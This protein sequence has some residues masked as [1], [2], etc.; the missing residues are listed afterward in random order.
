MDPL[1]KRKV[2]RHFTYGMHIIL[3]KDG[4]ELNG[5]TANFLTQV[6]FDPPL[7]ALSV[8][9]Q[10]RSFPM[11]QHAGV[12]TINV[13]QSGQ[14]DIAAKLGKSA[15]KHPQKIADS[16]VSISEHDGYP[17]LDAALGWVACKVTA[18]HETGDSHTFFA[19][20]IGAGELTE[21]KP[22]TMEETGFKHAG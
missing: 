21:G 9:T 6:S 20:V 17:V 11:I 12:F 13:L 8:E 18:V 19:E 1:V 7:I 15:L 22:L 4:D 5:F 16:G 3:V 14:R 10:T 2:L